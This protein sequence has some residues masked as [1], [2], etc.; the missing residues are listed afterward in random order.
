VRYQELE[1]LLKLYGFEERS[2][3]HGTSHHFWV[4]GA[5]RLSVPFR[6]SHVLRVYVMQVLKE[7]E[8]EDDD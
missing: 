8:G 2:S 6:R 3:R 5:K 4:R 1:Q 7:T